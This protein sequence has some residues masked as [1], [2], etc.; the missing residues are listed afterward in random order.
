M[1]TPTWVTLANANQTNEVNTGTALANST[2]LTDISPGG[3]TLGQAYQ[4]QPAQLYPGMMIRFKAWGIYSTTGTPTL[5]LGI[6]Y[7]GVAGVALAVTAA[8]TTASG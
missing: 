1:S 3:N 5:L 6:Y 7:G 2:T 8:T 4:T